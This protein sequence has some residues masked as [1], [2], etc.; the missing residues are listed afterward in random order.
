VQHYFTLWLFYLK[1]K[2]KSPDVKLCGN[3]AMVQP[4]KSLRLGLC[5]AIEHGV[6]ARQNTRSESLSSE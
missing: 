1:V 4:K 3:G 6:L 5:A 2:Y